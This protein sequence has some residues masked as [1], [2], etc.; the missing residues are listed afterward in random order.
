M[1]GSLLNKCSISNTSLRVIHRV[2]AGLEFTRRF[3]IW[4]RVKSALGIAERCACFSCCRFYSF[5]KC[6]PIVEASFGQ[7]T[8]AII[9]GLYKYEN[10]PVTRA[11]QRRDGTRAR[12]VFTIGAPRYVPRSPNDATATGAHYR[13][14]RAREKSEEAPK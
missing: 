11:R 1:S 2:E 13:G 4:D 5:R 14:R 6:T 12:F 9:S 7:C 3:C 8:R 10:A